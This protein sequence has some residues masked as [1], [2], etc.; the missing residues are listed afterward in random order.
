MVLYRHLLLGYLIA[1]SGA[2]AQTSY[3]PHGVFSDNSRWDSEAV[4]INSE[5]FLVAHETSLRHP[6]IKT[7]TFRLLWSPSFDDIWIVRLDTLPDQ[8]GRL[9]IKVIG[10]RGSK[11]AGELIRVEEKLLSAATIS[12]FL[13]MPAVKDFWT[14][15]PGGRQSGCDGADWLLEGV[16]RSKYHVVNQ[17]SPAEGPVR[18]IGQYLALV[19]AGLHSHYLDQPM[20]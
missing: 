7:T 6:Q 5:L 10:G 1:G 12:T 13:G 11:H 4:K 19:L 2:L 9:T 3:V 15:A 14:L 17:W 8:S 18:E 20:Y 16:R